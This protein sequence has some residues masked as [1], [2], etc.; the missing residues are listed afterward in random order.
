MTYCEHRWHIMNITDI[1]WTWVTCWKYVNDMLHMLNRGN[2]INMDDSTINH[3][4]LGVGAKWFKVLI[5]VPLGTYQLRAQFFNT[6]AKFV[7]YINQLSTCS[8]L[9]N[10][11]SLL[12]SWVLVEHFSHST[13]AQLCWKIRPWFVSWVYHV[14]FSFVYFISFDTLGGLHA[15]KKP[16]SI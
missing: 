15:F 14:I 11:W 16:F 13:S 7:F 12:K 5:A 1:C 9:S 8:I 4:A 6:W 3:S 10:L 2:I